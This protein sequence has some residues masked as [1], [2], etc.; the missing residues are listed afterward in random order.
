MAPMRV[1]VEV[2]ARRRR[3]KDRIVEVIKGVVRMAATLLLYGANA[4]FS[5]LGLIERDDVVRCL[6]N[7]AAI[8]TIYIVFVTERSDLVVVRQL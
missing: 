5:S 8:V 4:I 6:L 1:M 3:V 2:R 7:L